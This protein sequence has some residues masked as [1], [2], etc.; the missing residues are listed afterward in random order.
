MRAMA[1]ILPAFRFGLLLLAAAV[2]FD[3]GTLRAE[4]LQTLPQ[5]DRIVVDP[6]AEANAHKP[7]VL[8]R[9][10]RDGYNDLGSLDHQGFHLYRYREHWKPYTIFQPGDAGAFEDAAVA[11]I[12]GD[13]WND[14]VLGGWGNRT[15]WA[16]NPAGKGLDPYTNS[17]R[18]HDIDNHR[19][20][21]E[22]CA[23][24]L[25]H[26]GHCDIVTTSGIYF[27]GP[28]PDVWTFVAIERSGQGTQVGNVLANRDG[29][30]DVIAVRQSGGT[31][32]IAWFEN[33]GHAGRDPL[34]A[35]W[36][37][38]VI[39][40]N[41]GAARGA[42]RDMNEL[43]F[44]LG[45]INGDGRADLV[46][47]SMGEG[48]DAG[49]D[50]RQIGD[51]LVWYEAPVNPRSG[52]WQKHV[53]SPTVAWVHASSIELADFAGDGHLSICY[54][55]QDQSSHRKDGQ[56]ARQLAIF[57]NTNGDGSA[58]KLQILSQ[59]PDSG[60]GG[61]NSRVGI[62]GDDRRPSIFTS[63]HGYFGDPNPLLLWR[64]RQ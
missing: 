23:A 25:N 6:T 10:S 37:A 24:D 12:N 20:S 5:F 57:H 42:N 52:A 43:A 63:L 56:P 18:V 14:I 41:P 59:Y 9:F 35:P 62:I 28:S 48:P 40:P 32:Q 51:G 27:Q 44:A 2:L 50:N 61:F 64:S 33:P 36:H 39:D 45:D 47:A 7:K 31:N 4:P 8:A 17:W 21:H 38:H 54:A 34:H 29:Y 46:V 22:V 55:E 19:F 30:P 3:R 26:D 11:D 49:D 15:I 58:W 13:G 60:A 16:E 53:I 1:A